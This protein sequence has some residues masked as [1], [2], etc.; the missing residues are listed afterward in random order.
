MCDTG[1]YIR[2]MCVEATVVT[3]EALPPGPAPGAAPA[4]PPHPPY[5]VTTTPL[6]FYDKD[7]ILMV[8]INL[9]YY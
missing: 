6:H 1:V 8:L 3:A 7:N 4:P 5:R 2:Q 9:L